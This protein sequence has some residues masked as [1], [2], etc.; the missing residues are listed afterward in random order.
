MPQLPAGLRTLTR[1]VRALILIGAVVLAC[2]PPLFWLQPDW[3]RAAGPQMAN[4]GTGPIVVDERALWLGALGSLPGMLLGLY[5]LWQLWRLFGEYAA[6][7]FFAPA[8]QRHLRRF[9]WAVLAWALMAPLQRTWVALAL[10]WGN[11][12]GQRMLVLGLS[13]DDYF[14]ILLG[15]VLLA[16]ATVLAEA[17]RVAEENEGFV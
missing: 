2:V 6:G 8:P 10:T 7:R 5:T 14:S 4:L 9:A 13:G 16:I 3:V 17:A 11:P 1:V 15:A 12:P